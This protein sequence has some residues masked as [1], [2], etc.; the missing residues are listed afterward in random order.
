MQEKRNLKEIAGRG[1]VILDLNLK[2]KYRIINVYLKYN[3]ENGTTQR[4]YFIEQV[5]LIK[6]AVQMK[7]DRRPIILIK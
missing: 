3:P 4:E 5:N 2:M 7:G 1:L 6:H